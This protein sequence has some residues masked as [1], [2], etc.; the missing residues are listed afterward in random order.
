M[1]ERSL[2]KSPPLSMIVDVEASKD[3]LFQ[4]SIIQRE[5]S[6]CNGITYVPCHTYLVISV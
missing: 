3:V 2:T 5:I 4:A 6:H 1:I